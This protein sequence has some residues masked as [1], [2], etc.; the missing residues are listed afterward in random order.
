MLGGIWQ[1]EKESMC[2]LRIFFHVSEREKSKR[3]L[4]VVDPFGMYR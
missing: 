3:L 2:D 1:P 4:L